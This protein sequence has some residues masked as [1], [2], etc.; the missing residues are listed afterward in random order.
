MTA[1][2]EPDERPPFHLEPDEERLWGTRERGRKHTRAL[3]RK[4][5]ELR[6]CLK[7][8]ESELVLLR[9]DH[10]SGLE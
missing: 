1:K 4:L 3:L 2:K 8:A 9:T 7:D 6:A 5:S 10:P